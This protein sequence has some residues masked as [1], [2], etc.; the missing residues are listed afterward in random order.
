[1]SVEY[2]KNQQVQD[3]HQVQTKGRMDHSTIDLSQSNVALHIG[4]QDPHHDFLLS[5]FECSTLFRGQ[6]KF[7]EVGGQVTFSGGANTS[8]FLNEQKKASTSSCAMEKNFFLF[9]TNAQMTEDGKEDIV[10]QNSIF[11]NKARWTKEFSPIFE[12]LKDLSKQ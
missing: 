2:S 5:F 6:A 12:F 9:I 1:M 11:V 4:K 7:S 8:S 10:F 3:L